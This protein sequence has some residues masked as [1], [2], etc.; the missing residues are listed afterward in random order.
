MKAV[1]IEDN[2][3]LCDMLVEDLRSAGYDAIGF[4]SV[5]AF[6]EQNLTVDVFLLDVN[7]PGISG[8]EFA[9][10]VRS[11]D[12]RVG[13]IVLSIRTGSE[14]RIEGYTCG[15]DV[16][17]QKPCGSIELI[18]AVNR[19]AERVSWHNGAKR[20]SDQQYQLSVNRLAFVGS[21]GEVIL[22]R[23]EIALLVALA[24]N[25]PQQLSYEECKSHFSSGEP[26]NDA[27]LEV[28][29][30]RLRKKIESVTGAKKSIIGVRGEGYRLILNLEVLH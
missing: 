8:L 24:Q 22:T 19:V 13:I 15:V 14:S 9:R 21:L 2:P 6:K 17:L 23:R 5:E 4:R 26:I 1:V 29:V 18:A 3:D 30:G 10:E 7:L 12:R 27:T 11:E 16:Y 25:E 20:H 28:G